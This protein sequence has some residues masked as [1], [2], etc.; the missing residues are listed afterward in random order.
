MLCKGDKAPSPDMFDMGILQEFWHA[1]L[2]DIIDL[3]QEFYATRTFV[4]SLN[5]F[6]ILVLIAK[7][8]NIKNFRPMSLVSSIN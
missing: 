7:V 3:F 6:F 8:H 4:K 1:M 5:F 2:K